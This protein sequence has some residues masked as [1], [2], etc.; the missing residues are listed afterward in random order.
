[1]KYTKIFAFLVLISIFY[2]NCSYYSQMAVPVDPINKTKYQTV[3]HLKSSK[4]GFRFLTIPISIPSTT[5]IIENEIKKFSA[6]GIINTEITFSEFNFGI[7]SFPNLK[8]EG[9]IVKTGQHTSL[10]AAT[11]SNPMAQAS[12]STA[13]EPRS[14]P[15]S[16]VESQPES[17]QETENKPETI[18]KA[19]SED[20]LDKTWRE[21][22]TKLL[23]GKL[24]NTWWYYG[25]DHKTNISAA[26]WAKNLT[27]EDYQ[28]YSHQQI[29]LED[30]LKQKLAK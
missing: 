23:E 18:S 1:M 14:E 27:H 29:S 2:L 17:T 30:W 7:F 24:Y 15:A 25:K 9:D 26:D 8:I 21:S 6:D 4:T 10:P 5:E 12:S 3:H 13:P 19:E 28:E 16:V 11:P 22:I 20:S